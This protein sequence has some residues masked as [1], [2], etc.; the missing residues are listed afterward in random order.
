MDYLV[1]GNYLFE[2]SK[3]PNQEKY[4]KED[5]VQELD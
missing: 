2:K 4:K 3:Q 5:I 1:M